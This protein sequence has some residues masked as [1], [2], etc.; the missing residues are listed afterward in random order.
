MITLSILKHR[1][2]LQSMF[3]LLNHAFGH[4]PQFMEKIMNTVTESTRNPL[5]EEQLRHYFKEGYIVVPDLI[6]ASSMDDV[7]AHADVSDEAL[8]S[9]NW[10]PVIFD[11]DNP[12][13]QPHVHRLLVEPGLI[14][15]VEQIFEVP[16]RVYYGMLAVV[17]AK[18]G[19]GLPWH[20]DD[21]YSQ[22]IGAALNV[23]IALCD[24]TPD[25][26]ILWVAPGTHLQGTQPSKEAEGLG[27]HREAAVEPENGIPL[28]PMK[29]GDAC[30]FE[31][32][33]YHRS[34]KNDTDEHR[35][36]YAAQFQ[37]D[38]ARCAETGDK[39]PRKMR[40]SQLRETWTPL[41]DL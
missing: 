35:Y 1:N 27:G 17:P 22:V 39:D 8:N 36:A 13:K 11:H 37:A 33:T 38:Y 34:L 26:A 41:L 5:T 3:V 4:N 20:Q 25:K 31:R 10:S 28:P 7:L 16:A 18:G 40:A 9:G 19:N 30:I 23:F 14:S 24:I 6:P 15:A 21:Q 2:V 32:R 12:N 29:K